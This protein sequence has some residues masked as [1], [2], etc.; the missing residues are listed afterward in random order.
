MSAALL[1]AA[2]GGTPDSRPEPAVPPGPEPAFVT[3]APPCTTAV[4]L[5]LAGNRLDIQRAAHSG[6]EFSCALPDPGVDLSPLDQAI[7]DDRPDRVRTLLEAGADPNVR[8]HAGPPLMW[9]LNDAMGLRP[10]RRYRAA[11]VDALLTAGADPNARWCPFETRGVGCIVQ[12][13]VTP[14]M[15]AST[16]GQTDIVAL[17]LNA[18]ADPLAT[19]WI[20]G[21]AYGYSADVGTMTV[22]LTHRFPDPVE[23]RAEAIPFLRQHV[24]RPYRRQ[25]IDSLLGNAMTH[26]ASSFIASPPPPGDERTE[27]HYR[28]GRFRMLLSLGAD[29]NERSREND[30]TALGVA[31]SVNSPAAAELLLEYGANPNLGWCTHP[32]SDSASDRCDTAVGYSPLEWANRL[33]LPA[34][35]DLLRRFGGQ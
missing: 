4:V 25:H 35:A 12:R 11:I 18:G 10:S 28:F 14:L 1:A 2:C 6:A 5:A 32:M 21:T 24:V 34:F 8:V 19:D 26:R 27:D 33:N 15:V 16:F 3:A 31:M 22:L 29:P 30:L 20:D 17:L 9:A 7:V 13:G 23:R